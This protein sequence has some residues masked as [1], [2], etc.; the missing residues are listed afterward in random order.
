MAQNNEA[1][2]CPKCGERNDGVTDFCYVCG[3][4]L[5]DKK[6][7]YVSS[8]GG[9]IGEPVS[10]APA[11]VGVKKRTA[12]RDPSRNKAVVSS[13]ENKASATFAA[14][15][16]AFV[17]FVLAAALLLLLFAPAVSVGTEYDGG[18]D[19]YVTYTPIEFLK[20]GATSFG[21]IEVSDE[22]YENYRKLEKSIGK[23]YNTVSMQ[24]LLGE[25]TK[26]AVN[27]HFAG[28]GGTNK[29]NFVV[30]LALIIVYASAAILS[31]LSSLATLI[32]LSASRDTALHAKKLVKTRRKITF[33]LAI[34]PLCV[35]T[36]LQAAHLN[37]EGNARNFGNLG[38]KAEFGSVLAMIIFAAVFGQI[39]YFCFKRA[40]V[41]KNERFESLKRGV[42]LA[43]VMV[44]VFSMFL[45]CLSVKMA[46]PANYG[47]AKTETFNVS[48]S[49]VYEF[50]YNDVSF[51]DKLGNSLGEDGLIQ[52]IYDAV[53]KKGDD[54]AGL[55]AFYVSAFSHS[56]PSPMFAASGSVRMLLMLLSA[57]ILAG[58]SG[59]IF[60]K[61]RIKR[62]KLLMFASVCSALLYFI[63]NIVISAVCYDNIS[64]EVSRHLKF[65]VGIGSVLALI[66]IITAVVALYIP[67]PQRIEVEY[68]NPDV[69]YAPYVT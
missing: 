15:R 31:V 56:D 61:K 26:S 50:S 4:F 66:S 1:C 48:P 24:T 33:L 19:C 69:S 60:E 41:N 42:A 2:F 17:T 64:F 35:V 52:K 14:K 38:V 45:P 46:V 44:M 5:T 59:Q 30:A 57:I 9:G 27:I 37:H 40:S 53:K 49:D 28:R 39:C 7:V 18:V 25:Y 23:V 20:L 34:I 8:D 55:T 43:A 16:H 21:I 67:N 13:V 63:S 36:L 58:I 51:Y 65:S 3:T 62:Q 68:D 12:D 22:E 6:G 29:L 54:G 47:D 32:T 10:T 11:A